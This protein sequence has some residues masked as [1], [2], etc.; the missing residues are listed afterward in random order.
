MKRFL[1]TIAIAVMCMLTVHAQRYKSWH[2]S[3]TDRDYGVSA[4]NIKGKNFDCLIYGQSMYKY[5]PITGIRI[6]NKDIPAFV[7]EVRAVAEKAGQWWEK[8]ACGMG[9]DDAGVSFET[10]F[11]SVTAWYDMGTPPEPIYHDMKNAKLEAYGEMQ[12]VGLGIVFLSVSP[13]IDKDGNRHTGVVL[14]FGSKEEIIAFADA[15]EKLNPSVEEACCI[16]CG[17]NL[18]TGEAHKSDCPYYLSSEV[19]DSLSQTA[20]KPKDDIHITCQ[21]C[22]ATFSGK[23]ASLAFD[24]PRN[25]KKGCP[26]FN[27]VPEV[28]QVPKIQ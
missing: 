9:V 3:V 13:I 18:T 25:H 23:S 12:S 4:E 17:V 1:L 6:A 7:K 21:Q 15:V 16:Y 14:P 19:S 10:N 28:P 2:S 11:R 5:I 27:K 24:N 20:P 22:G 8:K 26:L